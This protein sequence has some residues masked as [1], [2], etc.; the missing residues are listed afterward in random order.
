LVLASLAGPAAADKSQTH[1]GLFLRL[2]LGF[3][4]SGIDDKQD[5]LSIDGTGGALGISL[6]G[7]IGRNLILYGEL[8]DD[9]SVAPTFKFGGMSVASD[10]N[11]SA[12]AVAVG[13]GLAY[14][15][16]NNVY[17]GAT[18]GAAKIQL[19]DSSS[20]GTTAVASTGWG[21]A[22]SGEVGKEWWVSDQWGLGASLQ[23]LYASAKDP[24]NGPTW[25]STALMLGVSAT[26]N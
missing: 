16:D 19:H 26:Y 5:S 23:A 1:D 24:N 18:V 12:G 22:L 15:F 9:I 10:N 11:V 6:G 14:Y 17:L 4:W 7:A 20:N 3:G 25:T 8:F 13:P 2:R 21:W